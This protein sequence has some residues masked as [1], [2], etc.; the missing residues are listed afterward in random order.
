MKRSMYALPDAGLVPDD[1]LATWVLSM[2]A[3]LDF[4]GGVRL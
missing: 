4:I 2:A 1:R 3:A